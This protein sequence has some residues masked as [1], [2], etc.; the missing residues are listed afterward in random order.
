MPTPL[1]QW[2][3]SPI[4]TSLWQYRLL[5]ANKRALPDFI[6][7]GAQK[8]GT[9]SLYH[10]LGQHPQLLPSYRKEVHYFDGGLD[11]KMDSYAKG[12]SWYQAYFPLKRTIRPGQQTFEASPLYMFNPLA[13]QR[14]TDLLPKVKI[15]ALLRNPTERAISQY[16]HEKRKNNET[17][18][19]HEAMQREEER[20]EAVLKAGDYKHASFIHHTYKSRGHYKEQLERY[21][22]VFPKE[23][24]LILGSEE[25]FADPVATL[26]RTF[27]FLNVAP[28]F[29]VNNLTP[30]NVGKNKSNVP[31][32]TIAYLNE[33]FTPHIR[34][35]YGFLGR[36]FGW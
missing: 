18:P 13:P 28:E 23:N 16:F 3:K 12:R 34:E 11:P 35:L 24:I 19:I 22:Q 14:I 27:T 17:L 20:L 6:I 33:Y 7:I 29:K 32:E 25:L 26:Q 9:A 5:T 21:F 30:H 2:L 15:I 8:A 36:D 4:Q 10:Y 1:P 31:A